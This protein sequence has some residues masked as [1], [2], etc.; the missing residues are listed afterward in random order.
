MPVPRLIA[1]SAFLL[2]A[3]GAAAPAAEAPLHAAQHPGACL[4]KAEQRAAVHERKAIPLAEAIKILRAHGKHAEVV[5]ARL[6]RRDDQLVYVLTLLAHSGKVIR[7]S[8]DAA[9]GA[10]LVNTR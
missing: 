3:L 1:L 9:N 2:V 5:G 6:C 10:L 4:T 7:T 8:V